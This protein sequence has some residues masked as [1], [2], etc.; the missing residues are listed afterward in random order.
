M[1]HASSHPV[2][3]SMRGLGK[4]YADWVL[5]DVD[6][7]IHRGEVH[8]LIGAN[9]AGKSTL[10]RIVSGLVRSDAGSMTIA[11]HRH[12]PAGK[13]EAE[14]AGVQIV[15]QELNLIP[16]LTI[17]ENLMLN[18]LPRRLG[19]I[20]HRELDRSAW[21]ALELVGLTDID[22]RTSVGELGV[23]RQQLIEIAA[24]LMR[25][26]RILILDEP[27]AA[28]TG[29]Q[30]DQLFEQVRKLKQAGVGILYVSH[31]MEEIRRIA[32]RATILRDGRLVTTC[33]VADLSVDEIVRLMVGRE[34][35]QE[36]RYRK[37][38]LGS[39]AMRV[40]GLR[41]GEAVRDVDLE[42]RHG[43]LLGITGLI[44]SGRT[45]LLRAI[46]GADCA[47]AGSVRLG[48]QPPRRFRSPGEAV[49][50]GIAMIPE[51]RK[52]HGLLL[53]RSLRENTTLGRL[54]CYARRW[55]GWI[56]SRAENRAVQHQAEAMDIRCD[57]I[58]QPVSQLSGGNQQKV[59]IAR[60]LLH[61]ADV[62]LFD[63]PTRGIDVAAKAAIYHLLGDLVE[64]GK[65]IVVVSSDLRELMA[66]CDRI[67]VMSAGRIAGTF[68]RAE[69]TQ[70]KIMAAAISGYLD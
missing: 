38:E 61:D 44:G 47:D 28:L 70:D 34:V 2:L 39:V 68:E 29:P 40:Q 19:F 26:C 49:A 4:R 56:D 27:T 57:S 7:D 43:E 58:E 52:Q 18:R 54:G 3:L 66:I 67:A 14:S 41:R 31:R 42:V 12:E 21:Q 37:H 23:G 60:W 16:T 10:V 1:N 17:A 62:I 64:H 11:G 36:A 8:A 53:A 24:A 51:D 13:A 20:R 6:L 46:F 35:I 15:Q 63:E 59:V 25:D 22:P 30:V 69:W 50:A 55:A 65:A 48:K 33:P 5:Q 45:E 9:G 32:D